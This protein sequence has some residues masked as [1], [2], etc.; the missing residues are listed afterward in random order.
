MH[1]EYNDDIGKAC[2]ES[3]LNALPDEWE[4]DAFT[5]ALTFDGGKKFH[6]PG[7]VFTLDIIVAVP[8]RL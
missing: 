6:L 8:A 3:M 7:I 4:Q 2:I 1:R 5:S